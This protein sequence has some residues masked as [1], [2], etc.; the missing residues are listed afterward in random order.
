MPRGFATHTESDLA[1]RIYTRGQSYCRNHILNTALHAGVA[2]SRINLRA[3]RTVAS[4][5]I[6]GEITLMTKIPKGICGRRA[7]QYPILR[8]TVTKLKL[9]KMGIYTYT[10]VR[11]NMWVR[12]RRR[13]FW[14]PTSNNQTRKHDIISHLSPKAVG[15]T[16]GCVVH[17]VLW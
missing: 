4:G 15:L 11:R 10:T 17:F 13:V 1:E 7:I 12:C 5:P 8:Y 14:V 9:T 16:C 2:L 3:I 6:Q